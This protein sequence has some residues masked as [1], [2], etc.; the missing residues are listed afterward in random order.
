MNAGHRRYIDHTGDLFFFTL[1]NSELLDLYPIMGA[2]D[3]LPNNSQ[4]KCYDG[5]HNWNQSAAPYDGMYQFPSI[6]AESD[7]RS[8]RDT[9]GVVAGVNAP[10][11]PSWLECTIC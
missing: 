5:M 8:P 11:N 4:F 7:D 2:D 9:H 6:I 3:A 10:R 1:F